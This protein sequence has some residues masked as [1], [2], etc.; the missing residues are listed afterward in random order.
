[1]SETSILKAA[2]IL[3]GQSQALP[4]YLDKGQIVPIKKDLKFKMLARLKRGSK[5]SHSYWVYQ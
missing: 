4:V 1:M 2:L 5:L 3:L